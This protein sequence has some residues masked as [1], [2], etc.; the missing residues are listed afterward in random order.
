MFQGPIQLASLRF[1][2]VDFQGDCDAVEDA[3]GVQH[4]FVLVMNRQL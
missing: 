3:G 1:G 4:G 2:E